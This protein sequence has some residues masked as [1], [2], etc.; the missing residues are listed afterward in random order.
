MPSAATDAAPSQRGRLA[1]PRADALARE[2]W[3]RH[4]T[5]PRIG[6]AL[7]VRL[8]R[9]LLFRGLFCG[10]FCC[11]LWSADIHADSV[12]IL[13]QDSP[14]AGSQYHAVA[15]VWPQ[16]KVGDRLTL[17]READNRHDRRAV[18]V[19]WNGHVLGYVPRAENRA[20]AAALD[21]GE[22]LEARITALRD[23]ADPWRRI[24]FAVYLTL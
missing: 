10:L 18:R 3:Q 14:L 13:V 2:R 1:A 17:V 5:P 8:R 6:P 23:E 22:H 16:L 20:V 4:A 11:L 12:Q 24:A 9:L 7:P 15:E 21:R 19:D